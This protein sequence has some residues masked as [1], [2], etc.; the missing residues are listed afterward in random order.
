MITEGPKMSEEW[1]IDLYL[2]APP[3]GKFGSA[4]YDK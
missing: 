3:Q 1:A 4:A 2:S